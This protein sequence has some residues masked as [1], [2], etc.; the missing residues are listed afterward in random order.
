MGYS[1]GGPKRF[2]HDL[3]TEQQQQLEIGSNNKSKNCDYIW[4]FNCAVI[5]LYYNSHVLKLF[6]MCNVRLL[7]FH[8]Y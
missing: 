1:P 2:R 5:K 6:C 8:K 4:P 3:A 7:I